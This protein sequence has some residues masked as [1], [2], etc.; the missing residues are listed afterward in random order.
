VRL[1]GWAETASAHALDAALRRA[2]KRQ[3]RIEHDLGRILRQ[4]LERRLYRELGFGSFERYA[5][6]RI[7][8]SGRT[9]R[10]WVQMARLGPAGSAV[11]GAFRD[12]LLTPKSRRLSSRRSCPPRSSRRPSSSRRA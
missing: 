1:A 10:R 5:R 2:M 4:V 7:D 6:E 8:I 9:A 12:G 3:Q 11:A